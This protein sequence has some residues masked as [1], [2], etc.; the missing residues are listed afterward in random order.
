E[1]IRGL[2]L[3]VSNPD[4]GWGKAQEL[5]HLIHDFKESGKFVTAF[6]QTCNEGSYYIALSADELY[7]QPHSFVEF[8]GFAAEIPF[9]KGTFNKL[10]MEP[11]VENIGKY[12][13]AGDILKR[14]SMS[15][16]HREVTEALL[17][18]HYEEFV[19]AVCGRRG[20]ERSEFED[21]LREGIYRSEG[22]LEHKLVDNLEYKTAVRNLLKEKVYGGEATDGKD[23]EL[24]MISVSRYARVPADEVGL[25]RGEKIALIYAVG[26]IVSGQND[27]NPLM[28][29]N[30]GSSSIVSLL[31]EAKDNEDIK[32]VVLRVDSPGGSALASDVMW[33]EIEK[34]QEEKPVVISMSDVAASGGYWISMGSDAIVAHP[35]TLTGSIG[36]VG[37][38][39]DLSGTYDK[40]GMNWE[41]VKTSEHADMMTDKRPMTD[42][43][44]ETFRENTRAIYETFVQ[45]VADGRNKTRDAV[46]EIAQGRVWTGEQALEIGLVDSLGGLDAALTIVKRKAEIAADAKT[47]WVVFPKPKGFFQS[48]MERFNVRVV[49][50]F[51][52][53]SQEWKIIQKLPKET[54]KAL[55]QIAVTSLVSRG[56]FLAIEPYVPV[57][58]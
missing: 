44:W 18:S 5:R 35:L 41:I 42:E 14:T 24:R 53:K 48:L 31:R 17:N 15:P 13:S 20:L 37:A 58:R 21:V 22:A 32:A 54:R 16:A 34:V 1:R 28:G 30:M 25:G 23:R 39:F 52:E 11:Q 19:Q 56:E 10:G 55:K 8:N 40:L 36:V 45:K 50:H 27:Y 3:D 29:R 51:A 6:M 49:R 47:Q 46:H 2:Y 4:L 33:A 38:I 12:K 43:E 57:I 9:L 26:N 7:L